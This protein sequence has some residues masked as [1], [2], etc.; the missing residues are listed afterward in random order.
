MS[1][2]LTLADLEQ[3]L[4]NR[5]T[6][7]IFKDWITETQLVQLIGI[8]RNTLKNKRCREQV[9]YSKLLDSIIM[10]YL[11]DMFEELLQKMVRKKWGVGRLEMTDDR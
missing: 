9:T 8:S 11:P 10:Y 2:K 7:E 4:D 5:P 1:K 3:L 6:P